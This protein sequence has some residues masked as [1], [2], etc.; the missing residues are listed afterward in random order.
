MRRKGGS[1]GKELRLGSCY[2]RDW[3]R[4]TLQDCPSPTQGEILDTFQTIRKW[5]KQPYSSLHTE[6]NLYFY[7]VKIIQNQH[8]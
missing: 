4:V 3:A 5:I 7:S 2:D 8:T 1:R 6:Y